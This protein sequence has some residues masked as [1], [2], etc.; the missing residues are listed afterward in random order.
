MMSDTRKNFYLGEAFTHN[1][2]DLN[3]EFNNIN[4]LNEKNYLSSQLIKFLIKTNNSAK[5]FKFVW[6]DIPDS[7]IHPIALC[8]NRGRSQIDGVILKTM[9]YHLWESYY[10]KPDDILFKDKQNKIFWRGAATGNLCYPANRFS[11]IEKYFNKEKNIDVGFSNTTQLKY[12]FTK[13]VK[14]RCGKT[15]F[16]NN[17]YLLSLEG[18]AQESGLIWKLNSNS[19][20][21]MPKP[22]A[23]S[24]L[25]ETSLVP[26]YHYV[27][28][29]DDFSDLEEKL[30][31]CDNHQQECIEI[32]KNANNF[33]KQFSNK[34][35]EEKL[36]LDVINT[37]FETLKSRSEY[38]RSLIVPENR[39][40]DEHHIIYTK[41]HGLRTHGYICGSPN[42]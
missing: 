3:C 14:G 29:S 13:Y 25:M 37:Y 8:K 2:F 10:R 17:K 36:E 21:L 4:Q 12:E 22:R 20:V 16:L 28:L 30:D 35:K 24:W 7:K 1:Q 26:D 15:A 11:L 38:P 19:L 31:W 6:G 32:V 42:D 5:Y 23:T 33:M 18:N 9:S 34:D 41:P 39:I 40:T 27:L